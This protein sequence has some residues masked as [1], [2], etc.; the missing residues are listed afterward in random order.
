MGV[1]FVLWRMV[2]FDLKYQV[3]HRIP[4]IC[5]SQMEIHPNLRVETFGIEICSCQACSK[6]G[7]LGYAMGSPDEMGDFQQK[8]FQIFPKSCTIW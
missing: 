8:I 7:K 4:K 6:I 1:F 5:P 3:V 2:E